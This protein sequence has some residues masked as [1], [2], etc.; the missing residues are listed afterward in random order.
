[1]HIRLLG[2]VEVRSGDQTVALGPP[3]QRAVLA[4]LA[5]AAPHVVSDDRF[6]DGLWGE[7]PPARPLPALQVFVHG[8]RKA[9]RAVSDVEV[10]Q[11]VAPGYRLGLPAEAVDVTRFLALHEAARGRREDDAAAEESTLLEALAL[12]RGP[13]L[14]DVRASPFSANEATRLDELRLLAEE[15][16]YDA[17]LRLGRHQQLVATLDR[18]VEENPMRERLWGQLMTALYRSDRQGDALATYARAR[19]RLADELGIDPGAALQQLELAVL[20]QDPTLAA[21]P[22]QPASTPLT[23]GAPAA[24][25]VAAVAPRRLSALP[26]PPTATFGRDRLV[27]DVVRRL[28]DPAV[29]TVTLTGPGGAGKS[30]VGVL[31]AQAAQGSFPG[32]VVFLTATELSEAEQLAGEVALALTGSDAPTG[33]GTTSSPTLVVLDNLE[34]VRDGA[35]VVR[36]LVESTEHLTVLA[37]SR[38]PLGLRVEHDVPVPPLETPEEG[39]PEHLVL[40]SPAVQ[41]FLDRAA[42]VDPG[43]ELHRHLVDVAALCRFVDGFPLAI[44]LAAAHVRVLSPGRILGS[45]ENDLSLLDASGI[46]LPERQRSLVTTIQWSFDQLSSRSQLVLERLALFE[47]GFTVESVEAICADVPGVVE[48]LTSIAKARLIRSLPSTVEVRFVLLG[49]VRAF[50]RTRLQEHT[51]LPERH[52]ALTDHLLARARSWAH[53]LEGPGG[54]VTLGRYADAAAD[55]DSAVD[56]ATQDGR[57][58]LAVELVHTLVELWVASGRMHQGLARCEA[59]ALHEPSLTPADRGRLHLATAQL[60][61]HLGD[62]SRD[63]QE[64]RR[65]LAL[66]GVGASVLTAAR[67]YLG[68][69]LLLTGRTEEGAALAEQALHEAVEAGSYT[70]QVVCL[71]LLAISRAIAGDFEGERAHY[72]QRLSAVQARGDLARLADTLNT[73]AEI[74]LDEDDAATASA[75]AEESRSIAGKALPLEARDATITLAR[76]AVVEHDLAA[77][78]ERLTEGFA[79]ADRTGQSLAVAQCLRVAACLA[80][81]EGR[82]ELAVRAFSCAQA[83]SPSPSGTDDPIE[84]DL[85][86]HLDA[87]RDRLGPSASGRAWLLGRTLPVAS[88]RAQLAF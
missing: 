18:R 37:T 68:G 1:M 9:L 60:A 15:D 39:A 49:T 14:A 58:D 26:S 28:E 19:E 2:P 88:V 11:R 86:R 17:Q 38:L 27:H 43:L 52:A 31:S 70:V 33:A 55:L 47:R 63:E 48:S 72:E 81:L 61:Y 85:R 32:G 30:R 80:D 16:L 23:E 51:D 79:L 5:L 87:A 29:R 78:R 21:P 20:R 53:E 45:L 24:P 83:L 4:M 74:A 34:A 66:D 73:L 65:V 69:A 59:L 35:T 22:R 46:D 42:S 62:W 71:S 56:R 8:L 64:C 77:A 12:W 84:G 67:C 10:V 75:Y 50:A 3:R 41:M 54:T 6:V 82:P 25:P 40:D 13:A 57:P 76:A 36:D 44:E 7:D